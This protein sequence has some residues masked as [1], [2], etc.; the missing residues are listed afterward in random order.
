MNHQKVAFIVLPYLSSAP[1]LAVHL[2]KG[3]RAVRY[4]QLEKRGDFSSETAPTLK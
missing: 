3:I 4:L 2:P 1:A